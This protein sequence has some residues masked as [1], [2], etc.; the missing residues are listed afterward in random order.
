[1]K[2]PMGKPIYFVLMENVLGRIPDHPIKLY[3][4]KGSTFG[5][6]N[7]KAAGVGKDLDFVKDGCRVY[8]TNSLK[9]SS[10]EYLYHYSSQLYREKP[11]DG[12]TA[13]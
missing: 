5:R 7:D 2:A 11:A 13:S 6:R 10:F 9:L 8:G 4:V 1:M 12:C 3:D